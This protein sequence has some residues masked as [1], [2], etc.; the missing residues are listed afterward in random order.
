MDK[1]LIPTVFSS[2]YTTSMPRKGIR[3][4]FIFM[5]AKIDSVFEVSRQPAYTSF[6]KQILPTANPF[7]LDLFSNMPFNKPFVDP[8]TE[9]VTEMSPWTAAI[10]N[11]RLI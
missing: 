11:G 7:N 5:F 10:E 8:E 6:W 4:K 9:W 1:Q 2:I 3:C